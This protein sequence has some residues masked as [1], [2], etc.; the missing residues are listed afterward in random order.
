MP[1]TRLRRRSDDRQ[2]NLPLAWLSEDEIIRALRRRGIRSIE[3]VRFKQNRTRMISLSDDRA[4]LNLHACFRAATSDVLDAIAIFIRTPRHH[5]GYRDAVRRMRSWWDGQVI[6]EKLDESALRPRLCCA[7]PEQL[8][9][10]RRAYVRLNM[11]KFGGRLPANVTIR[12][13]NRMSRR[14][15]HVHY[16][17]SRSG[18]RVEE[19]ALNVDLMMAGNEKHLLDTLMHEMAHVEAWIEHGHRE[20][21]ELWRAV[22]RRI[23]CED[24]ACTRIRI[25]RRRG[26]APVTHVP[27]LRV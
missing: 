9:I 6:E 17:Q 18:R 20:H 21:G 19:I 12:L 13:S 3:Q 16:A 14:L 24:R 27:R 10:L 8:E 11:T 1:S 15:G 23:G 5:A 22:A 4:S 7:T 26:R 25:R 2:L